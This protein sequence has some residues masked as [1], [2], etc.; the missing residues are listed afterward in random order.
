LNEQAVGCVDT[1]LKLKAGSCPG[2]KWIW[3]ADRL[4]AIERSEQGAGVNPPNP[5]AAGDGAEFVA[6]AARPP[7]ALA[8][9]AFVPDDAW[10]LAG[11][12]RSATERRHAVAARIARPT[13]STMQRRRQ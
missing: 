3:F 5:L 7:F 8:D 6:C 12:T 9:V 10:V 13:A 1:T 11:A 2:A 4:S